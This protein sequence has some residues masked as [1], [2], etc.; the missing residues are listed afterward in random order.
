MR[1]RVGFFANN[2]EVMIMEDQT[3]I[4]VFLENFHLYRPLTVSFY[5]DFNKERTKG[6]VILWFSPLAFILIIIIIQ[7]IYIVYL[8][9]FNM[10]YLS[11]SNHY[12]YCC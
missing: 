1:V 10:L 7:F 9:I 4:K 2:N 12:K 6:L 3:T 8:Y 11:N 5:T